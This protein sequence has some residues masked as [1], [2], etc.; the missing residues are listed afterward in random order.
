MDYKETN[1]LIFGLI[2]ATIIG[3]ITS[4]S[5]TILLEIFREHGIPVAWV[6]IFLIFIIYVFWRKFGKKRLEFPNPN[7]SK[8]AVE[9][10]MLELAKQTL[11]MGEKQ[12]IF[13]IWTLFTFEINSVQDRNKIEPIW[14]ESVKI[15]SAVFALVLAY[16]LPMR[17]F[18][19]EESSIFHTIIVFISSAIGYLIFILT[20]RVIHNRIYLPKAFS[21]SKKARLN[22]NSGKLYDPDVLYLVFD[23]K[24]K[25]IVIHYNKE[26]RKEEALRLVE[27]AEEQY[28]ES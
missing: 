4:I 23:F 25:E 11:K 8:R 9:V 27:S 16:C 12:G 21:K 19:P 7:E 13:D 5:G 15:I 17:I 10:N 2:T 20:A 24:N 14:F 6:I 18:R 26:I 28:S 1:I 3:V 22:I